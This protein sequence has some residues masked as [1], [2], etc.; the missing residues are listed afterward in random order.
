[1]IFRSYHTIRS[2][3]NAEEIKAALLGKHLQIHDLD[4]EIYD[5]GDCIKIIPHA[6][7]EKHIYTLP[8]TR[9]QVNQQTKGSILKLMSK[10][11]KIDVGGPYMVVIFIVF[12]LLA[13]LMLL[14]FGKGVYDNTAYALAG[15]SAMAFFLL[16]LRLQQGYFDYIRKTHKWIKNQLQS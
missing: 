15:I 13:A 8:I 2:E 7:I 5:K 1:M 14:M 10:P 12:A 6:E 11:R 4:F 9:I 16:W 3:K